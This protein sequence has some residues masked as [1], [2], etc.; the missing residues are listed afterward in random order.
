MEDAKPY[1]FE[2]A[3]KCRARSKRS[4]RQCQAPAERG[5]RVCRFHGARAGAPSGPRNGN[6][7]NGRWTKEAIAFRRRCAALVREGR[8]A[9]KLL[10]KDDPA[11]MTRT[12]GLAP[13]GGL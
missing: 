7:R 2:A 10:N 8:E 4:G 3:P 1:P 11:I 6:Y 13:I 9:A 5:K 12:F